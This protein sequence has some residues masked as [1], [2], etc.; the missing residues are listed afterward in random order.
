[1]MWSSAEHS[2][3]VPGQGLKGLVVEQKCKRSE[4][5]DSSS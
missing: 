3:L 1:M 5:I 2:Y 4:E